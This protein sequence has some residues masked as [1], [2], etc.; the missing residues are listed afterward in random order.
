[1]TSKPIRWRHPL[2]PEW[3]EGLIRSVT[4]NLIASIYFPDL[5]TEQK[6]SFAALG[7]DLSSIPNGHLLVPER[8]IEHSSAPDSRQSGHHRASRQSARPNPV[9]RQGSSASRGHQRRVAHCYQCHRTLDSENGRKCEA[10]GWLV[11]PHDGACGCGYGGGR[12]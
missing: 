10:C 1:M 5:G 12:G 6:V 4:P 11:C 9:P 7:L 8:P 2:R 3:G